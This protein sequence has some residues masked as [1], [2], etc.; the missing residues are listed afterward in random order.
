MKFIFQYPVNF[1]VVV[2]FF[3]WTAQKWIEK[4]DVKGVTSL[5]IGLN[6]FSVCFSLT[7]TMYFGTDHQNKLFTAECISKYRC[8]LKT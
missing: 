1:F 3:T 7:N 5:D 4:N 6:L 2:F 8:I